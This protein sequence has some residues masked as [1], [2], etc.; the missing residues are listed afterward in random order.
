MIQLFINEGSKYLSISSDLTTSSSTYFLMPD[1]SSCRKYFIYTFS[2]LIVTIQDQT[3]VI[4][5]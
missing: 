3:P 2:C 1:L 5:T 4:Y